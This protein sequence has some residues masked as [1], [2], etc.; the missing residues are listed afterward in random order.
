MYISFFFLYFT[1]STGTLHWN[2]FRQDF[3]WDIFAW[4]VWFDVVVC[5]RIEVHWIELL[6]LQPWTV[7]PI[8]MMRLLS[9]LGAIGIGPRNQTDNAHWLHY[10][11]P[12][13]WSLRSFVAKW[14]GHCRAAST[15][16]V[17]HPNHV[18]NAHYNLLKTRIVIL[19]YK[20]KNLHSYSPL[21]YS[22]AFDCSDAL[23]GITLGAAIAIRQ[24]NAKMIRKHIFVSYRIIERI[25]FSFCWPTGTLWCR[26]TDSDGQPDEAFYNETI[27]K[28]CQDLPFLQS[29]HLFVYLISC[30]ATPFKCLK[31][32]YKI[33]E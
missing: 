10:F 31:T 17:V 29:L 30:I 8:C 9:S 33:S 14:I 24:N 25:R 26:W 1:L 13:W 22:I 19:N 7:S 3:H 21:E 11:Y 23:N 28:I 4:C 12:M 16:A 6:H 15:V 18:L 27:E 32:K 5:L 2:Q 20:K